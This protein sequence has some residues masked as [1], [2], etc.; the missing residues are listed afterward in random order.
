MT[1]APTRYSELTK[2]QVWAL[3]LLAALDACYPQAGGRNSRILDG[4]EA[5][6]RKQAK[7]A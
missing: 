6:R 1:S 4:Y 5:W 2:G 7:A 3:R